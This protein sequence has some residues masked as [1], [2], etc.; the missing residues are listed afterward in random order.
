M[1]QDGKDGRFGNGSNWFGAKH[2]F[3][4]RVETYQVGLGL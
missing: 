2:A 4:V 1:Y 3:L